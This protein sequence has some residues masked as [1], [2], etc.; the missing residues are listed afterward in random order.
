MLSAFFNSIS[1]Q[2]ALFSIRTNFLKKIKVLTNSAMS[3]IPHY[4]MILQNKIFK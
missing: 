1:F 2:K 4:E 3:F